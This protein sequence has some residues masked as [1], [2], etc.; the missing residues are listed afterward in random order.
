M[1][2]TVSEYNAFVENQISRAIY[3]FTLSCD[4]FNVF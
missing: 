1:S 2:R 4:L 3:D